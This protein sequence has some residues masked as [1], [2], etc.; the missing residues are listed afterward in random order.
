MELAFALSAAA[1][2][3]S[4]LRVGRAVTAGRE[5]S[6]ETRT[7]SSLIV[8]MKLTDLG[9]GTAKNS[10]L[11]ARSQGAAERT[12]TTTRNTR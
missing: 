8:E 10:R 9:V 11:I 12:I 5:S 7:F 1:F 4:A 6:P 2:S 3:A